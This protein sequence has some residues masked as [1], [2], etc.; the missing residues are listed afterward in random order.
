MTELEQLT[1]ELLKYLNK[2]EES[3]SGHQFRPNYIS[4]CRVLDGQ[5]MGKILKRM[6]ELVSFNRR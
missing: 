1:H 6:E 4:S 5:R 2:E 3:D